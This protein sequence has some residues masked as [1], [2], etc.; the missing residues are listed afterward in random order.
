MKHTVKNYLNWLINL[1]KSL[2]PYDVYFAEGK[3]ATN[4]N[5]LLD[6]GIHDYAWFYISQL[7]IINLYEF[8][9]IL[10]RWK[11]KQTREE[12]KLSD[13]AF[14][15]KLKAKFDI[16]YSDQENQQLISRILDSKIFVPSKQPVFRDRKIINVNT[17]LY[18]ALA[19]GRREIAHADYGN[20]SEG[21][22][23]SFNKLDLILFLLGII[24]N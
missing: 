7:I 6:D 20:N 11:F 9:N 12:W 8:L 16:D 19:E 18:E 15:K 22:I 3:K 5:L 4:N 10:H 17:S 2:Q 13:K 24:I 23:N 1:N 21:R 14:I